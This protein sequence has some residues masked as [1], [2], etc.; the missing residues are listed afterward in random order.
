[1]ANQSSPVAPDQPAPAAFEATP[2]RRTILVVDD[3]PTVRALVSAALAIR[4]PRYDILEAGSGSEALA[5][6][7]ERSPDLV[8]LDVALPD[9]DGFTVCQQLKSD[10]ATRATPVVMLT[11]MNL[12]ADRQRA[13][14]VGADGYVV[15]P[16]SPRGLLA[17]VDE[18][19]KA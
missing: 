2:P 4:T 5:L 10:P 1:M 18:Q 11:A 3:E 12:A 17:L 8:L 15:K 13:T 6:A 16:F 7:R 19:L 9:V 14:E